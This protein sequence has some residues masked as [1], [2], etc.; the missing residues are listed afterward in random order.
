MPLGV[1]AVLQGRGQAAGTTVVAAQAGVPE[2]AASSLKAALDRDWDDPGARDGALAEVLGL[3]DRVHAFVAGQ[4][5]EQA[6]ATAVVAE[7]QVRAKPSSR[8][9]CLSAVGAAARWLVEFTRSHLSIL[10]SCPSI[11]GC[12]LW[13]AYAGKDRMLS[14]RS[15]TQGCI[16]NQTL[17]NFV[18]A[19]ATAEL[20]Y[21]ML[22]WRHSVPGAR[23]S[24]WTRTSETCR[25]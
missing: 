21:F 4:A 13:L 7:R 2:L 18:A 25:R 3:L 11:S 19:A 17:F 5:G 23:S 10:W 24:G 9:R 1:I 6:A 22:R 8:A 14:A 20:S 16:V 15:L 12:A